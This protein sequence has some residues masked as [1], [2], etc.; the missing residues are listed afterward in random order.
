MSAS[1]APLLRGFPREADG[2]NMP[3]M[4]RSPA[5][6]APPR[7]R[8]QAP[9]SE[10]ALFPGVLPGVLLGLTLGALGCSGGDDGGGPSGGGPAADPVPLGD[11]RSGEGTYYDADGTGACAFDAGKS[12]LRVAAL[13]APDWSGSASCGACAA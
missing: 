2:A 9:P 11:P 1:I 8:A 5:P 12:P 4:I 6:T 3:L 7:L 13:N 10:R